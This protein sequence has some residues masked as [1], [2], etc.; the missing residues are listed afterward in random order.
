M[1][2]HQRDLAASLTRQISEAADIGERDD[3]ERLYVICTTDTTHTP[4]RI[5]H[6]TLRFLGESIFVTDN[7]HKARRFAE[8]FNVSLEA[9]GSESRVAAMR[10]TDWLSLYAEQLAE[11]R[12]ALDIADA[13][14]S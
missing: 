4:L 2:E 5:T 3:H 10:Y 6:E 13:K 8:R 11:L 7:E 9:A 12:K 1:T 14:E